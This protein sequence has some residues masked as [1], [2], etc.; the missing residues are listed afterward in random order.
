[1]ITREYLYTLAYPTECLYSD[2]AL[3]RYRQEK[4][5][6]EHQDRIKYEEEQ[7][8][9]EQRTLNRLLKKHTNFERL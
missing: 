4:E 9:E 7:N 8:A 6:K 5:C 1:M 2:E 3:I